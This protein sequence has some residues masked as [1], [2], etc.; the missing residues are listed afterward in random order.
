MVVIFVILMPLLAVLH[1][2]ALLAT[3]WACDLEASK[4]G[5]TLFILVLRGPKPQ[6]KNRAM[7]AVAPPPISRGTLSSNRGGNDHVVA[8]PGLEFGILINWDRQN[9]TR[10]SP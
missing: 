10:G 6:V 2:S 4:N 3:P 9:P 8:A 1:A 5:Q 7:P